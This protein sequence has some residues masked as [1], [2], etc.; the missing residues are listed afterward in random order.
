M[1]GW[2]RE[3]GDIRGGWNANCKMCLHHSAITISLSELQV[4][5]SIRAH[6]SYF[7]DIFCQ[8]N[9]DM[10]QSNFCFIS[11]EQQH[12]LHNEPIFGS[13]QSQPS[14]DCPSASC[15]TNHSAC[16]VQIERYLLVPAAVPRPDD[17]RGD[18]GINVIH[19]CTALQPR[20]DRIQLYLCAICFMI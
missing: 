8:I 2:G 12:P 16:P 18:S 19:H 11:A 17:E 7:T 20:E 5:L 6:L 10:N 1:D 13:E 15:L 14:T 4:K 9:D 3:G